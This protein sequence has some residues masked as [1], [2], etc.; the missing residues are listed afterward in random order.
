MNIMYLVDTKFKRIM[1]YG[2]QTCHPCETQIL[3]EGLS[4]LRENEVNVWF[5]TK[6]GTTIA[7]DSGHLDFKKAG[8][9]LKKINIEREKIKHV[10]L[11][12]C[13]VDHCGGVDVK[14]KNPLFPNAKIYIGKG[15]DVYFN[16][17]TYRMKKLG[18]KLMNPVELP[19]DY[20]RLEDGDEFDIDGI[21]IR[22]VKISGHTLGHVCY[23]VDDKILFSG[24]CLA[25]NDEGGWSL[26]EFFTQFPQ[27]NKESLKRL[28]QIVENLP[29]KYVCTGHSGFRTDMSK[30]FAHID[31]S[32][33]TSKKHPFDPTA[34]KDICGKV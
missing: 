6:N 15:E 2:K 29:I 16:R 24:D 20:V 22:A 23:I 12:H 19:S 8:D 4:C 5:Y 3:L 18:I 1:L 31:Q 26:W 11:T 30:I 25:V 21:K 9:G 32:G 10:F 13:D 7:I 17:E 14:A 33:T 34:P 28:K 27:M